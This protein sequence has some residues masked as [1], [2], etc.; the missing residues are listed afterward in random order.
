MDEGFWLRIA[1]RTGVAI[2]GTNEGVI[3]VRDVKPKVSNSAWNLNKF[4]QMRGAPWA[5]VSRRQGIESISRVVIPG[6]R[7]VLGG[8]VWG[9]DREEAARRLRIHR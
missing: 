2:I 6:E 7:A 4:N 8:I 9:E 1:D 3:E 5:P